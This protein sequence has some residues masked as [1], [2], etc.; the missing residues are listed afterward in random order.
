MTGRTPDAGRLP[1]PDGKIFLHGKAERLP[2]RLV[3][4]ETLPTTI[5][6]YR[7][8][9]GGRC[10]YHVH[11]GKDECWLIVA[12]RGQAKVGDT[13]YQVAAGDFLLTREGT[14]HALVNAGAEDL[15]FVNI[16][17]PTGTGAISSVE[18]GD[19]EP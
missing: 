8:E 6:W 2:T 9:P 3:N 18:L 4:A 15:V 10:T 12:G 7:V 13:D 14:P 1:G 11:S 19:P 5:S 17:F 16:V